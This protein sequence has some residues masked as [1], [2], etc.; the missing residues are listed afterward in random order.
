[1]KIQVVEHLKKYFN[2]KTLYKGINGILYGWLKGKLDEV[3]DFRLQY[4][5]PFWN[6]D[7][8]F[9]TIPH[10]FGPQQGNNI[11][12]ELEA[13]DSHL[14]DQYGYAIK[15]TRFLEKGGEKYEVLL[16]QQLADSIS[17]NMRLCKF[18]EDFDFTQAIDIGFNTDT[19]S[20]A[21]PDNIR[22]CIVQG[23]QQKLNLN[24]DEYFYTNDHDITFDLRKLSIEVKLYRTYLMIRI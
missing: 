15:Y 1:M 5:N 21:N 3:D 17:S 11:K 4:W 16:V 2:K 23:I 24:P 18:V 14:Q 6:M 9:R 13:T 12:T 10:K 7:A 20:E 22:N 19:G 8:S